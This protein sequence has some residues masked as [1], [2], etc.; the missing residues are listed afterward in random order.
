[1]NGM[2]LLVWLAVV[3]LW[4]RLGAIGPIDLVRS[5]AQKPEREGGSRGRWHLSEEV[6]LSAWIS[7]RQPEQASWKTMSVRVQDR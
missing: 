7:L 4:N 3:S 1:V 2:I 6:A 5:R